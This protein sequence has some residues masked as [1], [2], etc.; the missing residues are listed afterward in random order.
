MYDE[1]IKVAHLV[2]NHKLYCTITEMIQKFKSPKEDLTR[3]WLS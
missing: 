3:V 2:D 1:T